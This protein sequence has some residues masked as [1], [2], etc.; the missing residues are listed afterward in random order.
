M[1][2]IIRRKFKKYPKND[3]KFNGFLPKKI[4]NTF[5]LIGS[6]NDK[7]VRMHYFHAFPIVE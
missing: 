3:S 2:R 4:G 6:T 1:L 5:D 7:T